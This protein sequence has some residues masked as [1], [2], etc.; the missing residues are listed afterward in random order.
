MVAGPRPWAAPPVGDPGGPDAIGGGLVVARTR[1][2]EGGRGAS[3]GAAGGARTKNGCMRTRR[4][5]EH[6]EV[7]SE[8]ET[9]ALRSKAL[10]GEVKE[11]G[12]MRCWDR[13]YEMGDGSGINR[14][15]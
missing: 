13:G 1:R 14:P 7:I 2:A 3:D 5:N 10:E 11:N 8:R 12:G 6:K 4:A 9:R 15:P